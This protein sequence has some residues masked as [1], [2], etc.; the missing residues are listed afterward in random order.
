V[1]NV[2]FQAMQIAGNAL[3]MSQGKG[4]QVAKQMYTLLQT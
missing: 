2:V 1:D 4:K 3:R